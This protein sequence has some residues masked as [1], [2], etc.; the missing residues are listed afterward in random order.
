[1]SFF[2]DRCGLKVSGTDSQADVERARQSV[3]PWAVDCQLAQPEPGTGLRCFC[4]D[5]TDHESHEAHA[6]TIR[7]HIAWRNRNARSEAN[8]SWESAR[9]L[10]DAAP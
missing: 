8:V 2:V 4:L 6:F 7:R 1:V 3:G 9:T 5:A 10:P